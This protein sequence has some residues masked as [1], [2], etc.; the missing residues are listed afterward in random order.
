M[1]SKIKIKYGTYILASPENKNIT[2]FFK[3][4]FG[5]FKCIAGL[6]YAK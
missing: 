6:L 3:T 1:H 2:Y 5:S 4:K